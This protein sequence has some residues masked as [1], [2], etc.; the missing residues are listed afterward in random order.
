NAAD[1]RAGGDHLPPVR[2]E[3]R[4]DHRATVREGREEGLPAGPIPY[5]CGVVVTGGDH[6]PPVGAERRAVHTVTVFEGRG[7]GLTAGRVPPP[8]LAFAFKAIAVPTGGDHP[9]PVRAERRA[10]HRAAV[11]PY[12]VQPR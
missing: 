9:P 12:L 4:A 6:P 11:E 3:P 8:P 1:G 5:P 10:I 2:A 7:E